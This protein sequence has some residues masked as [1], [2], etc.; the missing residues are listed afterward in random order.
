MSHP[1]ATPSADQSPTILGAPRIA[2]RGA[3]SP[4]PSR[5]SRRPAFKRSPANKRPQRHPRPPL[6]QYLRHYSVPHHR[7]AP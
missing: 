7:R 3:V 6:S 2:P 5:A 4:V 1:A